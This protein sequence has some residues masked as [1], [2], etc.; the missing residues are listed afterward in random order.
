VQAKLT[1]GGGEGV[2]DSAV[3][4]SLFGADVSK[5]LSC[6]RLHHYLPSRFAAL[7]LLEKSQLSFFSNEQQRDTHLR[8]SVARARGRDVFSQW[9]IESLTSAN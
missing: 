6:T 8:T 4:Q 7:S 2:P 5:E 9:L 1:L 3:E